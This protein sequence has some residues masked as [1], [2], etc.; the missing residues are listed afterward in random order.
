MVPP[1]DQYVDASADFTTQ[2]LTAS[3]TG[4]GTGGESYVWE[5]LRPDGTS[6]T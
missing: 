1:G 6:G 5:V 3:Q 4:A 2:Q